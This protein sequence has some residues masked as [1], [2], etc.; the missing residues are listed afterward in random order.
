MADPHAAV[1]AMAA[2]INSNAEYFHLTLHAKQ[3]MVEYFKAKK[4]AEIAHT[5]EV[6]DDLIKHYVDSKETLAKVS[7]LFTRD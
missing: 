3:K 2:F 5:T 1:D 4:E 6:Y 7:V